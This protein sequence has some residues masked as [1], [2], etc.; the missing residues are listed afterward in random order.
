[1]SEDRTSPTARR[2]E[3]VVAYFLC[4][5]DRSVVAALVRLSEA[6]VDDILA[7]HG[8]VDEAGRYAISAAMHTELRLPC[9]VPRQ[10]KSGGTMK[11]NST[12]V[13]RLHTET[14]P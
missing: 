7:E 1:M 6:E 4:G 13:N 9:Y 11:I 2:H 5:L 10:R 12:F 3:A 8:S 14:H